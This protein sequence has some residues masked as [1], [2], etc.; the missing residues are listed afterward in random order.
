MQSEQQPTP[1]ELARR[2]PA[3]V[4][5]IMPNDFS[6]ILQ[7]WIRD[8]TMFRRVDPH[9]KHEHFLDR[10]VPCRVIWRA[11]Q[12]AQRE[13]GSWD[14]EILVRIVNEW[15]SYES[16]VLLPEQLEL[17]TRSGEGGLIYDACHAGPLSAPERA[18]AEQLQ[19]RFLEEASIFAPLRAFAN[20]GRCHSRDVRPEN[21]Q[22]F[23]ESLNRQLGQNA[24]LSAPPLRSA[25]ELWEPHEAQ[26]QQFRGRRMIGLETGMQLL[27]RLTLGL[28][29]VTLLGAAPGTGKTALCLQLAAGVCQRSDVNNAVV[30]FLSLEL[31]ADDLMTRLKCHLSQIDWKDYM[32][33]VYGENRQYE[34]TDDLASRRDDAYRRIADNGLG[35]RLFFVDRRQL[36]DHSVES[37]LAVIANA[38]EQTGASRALLIHDYLQLTELPQDTRNQDALEAD[39]TRFRLLQQINERTRTETN[40]L[41]DT[42]L[43][44]SEARK[45]AG[46]NGKKQIWGTALADLMG[47]AR[48]GYGADAALFLRRMEKDEYER[49]YGQDS[50]DYEQHLERLRERGKSP[51]VLSIAKGRDGMMHGDIP[52]EFDFRKS[53]MC[54]LRNGIPIGRPTVEFPNQRPRRRQLEA[55]T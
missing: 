16:V 50:S 46:N 17:L 23:I 55:V 19:Q 49:Y 32:R 31:P 13:F 54:E 44:I 35:N 53:T 18:H 47:T 48:L 10:Q 38:K 52:I 22:E 20:P 15:D 3:T 37:I 43:A 21:V 34:F 42:V 28:R 33:G 1:M 45:P 30:V 6:K 26:L 25:S 51:L 29:G 9:L 40:P 24:S 12:Q 7:A 27:D 11:L 14:Y 36:T 4:S 39:K 5:I 8:P 41:G 2:A